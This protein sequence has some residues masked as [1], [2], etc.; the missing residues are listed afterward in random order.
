MTVRAFAPASVANFGVGFDVLGAALDG[1]GDVVTA[2]FR[3]EPGVCVASITG[4]GG[5]LPKDPAKNTAAVAASAVLDLVPD[6]PK[7]RRGL[8][9]TVEKGLPLA[10]G[11]GSSAASAA[12][13]ALAAAT[14]L[15][16]TDRLLLLKAVLMGENAG[17]GS[18]HGDNAFSALL[19]G[20]LLVPSSNPAHLLAPVPLPVPPALRLVLVH[21]DL[22]LSTRRAR[23]A[24][25]RRIA[26]ADHVRQSGALA[27][28]VAAL[29]RADLREVGRCV[30]SDQIVEPA[31]APLV[32]GYEAVTSA[33][34][35][36]GALGVALAGAGPSLLAISEDGPLPEAVGR[37]AVQAWRDEGVEAEARVHQVDVRGTRIED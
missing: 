8:V 34:R 14:L 33:M 26:L 25:P 28:L 3:E 2:A 4:D 22:H 30:S 35:R 17:D 1:P 20:L 10:S 19:G 13:G 11:L 31:R 9:L 37:A 23:A 29:H 24:L 21:P 27:S 15:G 12:A 6:R 16:I 7:E 36:A 32:P 5:R 18:W